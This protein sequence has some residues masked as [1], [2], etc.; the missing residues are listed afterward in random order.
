MQIL[1][2]VSPVQASVNT[3]TLVAGS[4]VDATMALSVSF[5]IENSG[6]ESIDY[7]VIAGNLEDLSDATVVQA[8][9]TLTTGSFGT[10]AV[11]IAPYSYYGIKIASTVGGSHGEATIYGTSKG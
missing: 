8:S 4:T 1:Y 10:Y 6:D 9:A 3:N 2:S 5:T 11:S 7:E